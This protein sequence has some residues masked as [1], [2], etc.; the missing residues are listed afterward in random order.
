[1]SNNTLKT[2]SAVSAA[3]AASVAIVGV[4]LESLPIAGVAALGGITAAVLRLRAR[5]GSTKIYS[6]QT[7]PFDPPGV[8]KHQASAVVR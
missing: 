8:K 4:M 5:Q 2:I 6:Q 3:T 7:L 1:M